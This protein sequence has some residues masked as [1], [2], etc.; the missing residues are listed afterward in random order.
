M[1]KFKLIIL[2]FDGTL[3]DS[4]KLIVDTMQAVIR[5]LGLPDRTRE[6]CSSTIGLPLKECFTS[7]IPMSEEMG[8][9]CVQTYF[10]IFDENN[11]PGA[12]PAF[13]GVLDTLHQLHREGILL[14]IASSRNSASL[15][16]FVRDFGIEGIVPYVLGADNVS[17][18]KPDPAPVLQ[19]LAH[20]GIAAEDTLVVGDAAFDIK[21]GANAHAFTCGVT[22]GNGS[23]EELKSAGADYL[24]NSFTELLKL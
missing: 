24:I 22:Y 19:T 21:M 12:V 11:V 16:G 23:A 6:E 15:K 2:D 20:F 1:G 18:A 7:I 5:E 8:D 17:K 10:R 9:R 14:S 4:N 3:G 13:P